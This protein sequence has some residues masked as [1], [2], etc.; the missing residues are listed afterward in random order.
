MIGIKSKLKFVN[1][2]IQFKFL[3]LKI[4]NQN[5]LTESERIYEW[6]SLEKTIQQIS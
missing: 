6:S 5:R 2:Q 1:I 3:I 4:Q